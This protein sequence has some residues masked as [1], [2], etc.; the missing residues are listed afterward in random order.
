MLNW[1]DMSIE[2]PADGQRCLTKMKHGLI[3]GDYD[4][5][6]DSFG[7]YYS[8]GMEWWA[9]HWVPIEEA[10]EGLAGPTRQQ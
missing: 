7:G 6:D 2:K 9:S 8:R 3:S 4:A 1:R 5:N 10:E